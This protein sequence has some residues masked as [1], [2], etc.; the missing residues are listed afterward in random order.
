MM[1]A[2]KRRVKVFFSAIV[3][4][5]VLAEVV[6]TEDLPAPVLAPVAVPATAPVVS[7]VPA[8]LP[9]VLEAIPPLG[10]VDPLRPYDSQRLYEDARTLARFYPEVLSLASIGQSALGNNI[11]LLKLGSGERHVLWVG[12][13]H[14]REVMTCAFLLLIAEEYAHAYCNLAPYDAYSA[15]KVH[16][17]L[18]EFTVY[19]VPMANPDGVDIVTA[20]G[21]ALVPIYS[22]ET[23]K[24]NAGGVNLN[25][26][27]P[28]DWDSNSFDGFSNNYL[29]NKGL[30][31]ASEPETLALMALCEENAFEFLVSCHCSGR[32]LYWRDDKNGETPGDEL[33]ARTIA[34][35]TGYA[36]LPSTKRA[37]NGWAGGLENWFRD[38]Y[39]RPAI[40][41]ELGLFDTA[42]AA[43]A[44]QFHTA[45]MA[46]WPVNK[47]LV[48]GVL[49][50]LSGSF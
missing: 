15:D 22:R 8:A 11:P 16:D 4:M 24:S 23:W 37:L 18:D 42:D 1:G 3:A 48:W 33:L 36:M 6:W 9:E 38:R 25:R 13:I 7:V 31:P 28:F 47:N 49:E 40:C 26:N 20:E 35:L 10:V 17:L 41:L 2:M 5:L 43:T 34:K 29:S 14:G 27:F 46:N 30:L 12:A 50:S 32:V 39:N 19:F 45:E 44:A 21:P